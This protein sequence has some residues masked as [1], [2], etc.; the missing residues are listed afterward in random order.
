MFGNLGGA[1]SI[2]MKGGNNLITSDNNSMVNSN[3]RANS[4]KAIDILEVESVNESKDI[5]SKQSLISQAKGRTESL[6]AIKPGKL[7]F[8][9]GFGIN[10]GED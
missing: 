2:H 10:L 9:K 7:D 4:N 5:P 3:E 8:S 6:Q 1:K